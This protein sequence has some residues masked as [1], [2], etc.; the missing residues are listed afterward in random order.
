MLKL[1]QCFVLVQ[2]L[3]G[4]R[5]T[6]ELKRRGAESAELVR[7]RTPRLVTPRN[8][9]RTLAVGEAFDEGRLSSKRSGLFD[10]LGR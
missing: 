9:W 3:R 7:D 4:R 1:D 10:K 2:G 6:T 5:G 8:I